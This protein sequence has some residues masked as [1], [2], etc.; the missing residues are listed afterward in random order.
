[1]LYREISRTLAVF[2]WGLAIPLA[3]PFFI[4][5]YCERVAGPEVYPQPPSAF[6]FFATIVITILLGWLFRFLGRKSTGRIFRREALLMVLLFYFM[7]SFIGGLPFYLNKTFTNPIDAFYETVSG[8]TT[9]GA[10]LMEG[11]QYNPETGK[12]IPITKTFV[13][14]E[15]TTYSY[16]GTIT[17]VIDS[18]TNKVLYTG[19]EAVSPALLFWRSMTQWL[20]GCGIVVLFVAILPALGVG[21]KILYQTE[22]TGPSKESLAPRIKETASHLWKIYLGL[23]VLEII[24][25]MVTNSDVSLFDA[26]T[27]TFSTLSTG[28][29]TPKNGS[30]GSFNN[31][32]TDIV[33]M[34]FMVLGSISFSIYFFCLRG[35]FRRLNDPELKAFLIVVAL[36]SLFAAWNLSGLSATSIGGPEGSLFHFWEGLRYGA[37]QII[38]AFTS[39][40]FVTANYDIWPFAIQLLMLILMFVGAMAGSTAGGIKMIRSQMLF[41]I[42]VDKIETIF[43]PD[44]VRT[45][46]VG[47]TTI[48][49]RAAM[50]VLCFFMVVV[51]LTITSTFLLVIDGVDP[52]TSISTVACWINN[53]GIAFRMGSPADSFAF[54]TNFGKILG[55]FLMIAGRLEFFAVLIAFVPAFWRTK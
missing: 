15:P 25:L 32:Y 19:I 43:R 28:G 16:Y 44:T 9:T 40:G 12:E 13:T 54:L 23:T 27:I 41:R 1:M 2:L 10:T 26:T 7:T 8:L 48:D 35:K 39:T 22:V 37:F 34:V 30:I 47:A 36:A 50:T 38:S 45:Y 18:S 21:G 52:E 53:V 42:I 3:F 4:A 51:I 33:V 17:P 20:G 6:A 24:L 46:R 31:P 14:G 55:S 5:I 11:K 49:N 29:F